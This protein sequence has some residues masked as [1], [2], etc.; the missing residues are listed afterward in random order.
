VLVHIRCESIVSAQ[1][2]RVRFDDSY[3]NYL[4]L[5]EVEIYGYRYELP[6]LVLGNDA[7]QLSP[8]SNSIVSAPCGSCQQ[9]NKHM[10]N[11]DR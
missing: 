5:A 10:T 3:T 9:Y 7:T 8:C 4:S 6:I 2:V 11:T 1:F